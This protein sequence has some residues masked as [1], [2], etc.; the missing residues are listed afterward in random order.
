MWFALLLSLIFPAVAQDRGARGDDA[1]FDGEDGE[2]VP[3]PKRRFYYANSVFARV[4]PL[5]LINQFRLGIRRRL[6]TS[7]SVL[8]QDTYAFVGP[9]ATVSPAF[10]RGGLYAEAQLLSVFRVFAQVEGAQF[11]GTFNQVTSF[12]STDVLYS[13]QT[14]DTLDAAEALGGWVF[15]TGFTVRGAAGPLVVR[16]TANIA[17]F[18]IDL[19]EGRTHFY[20]Q[21]WDRLA[22]NNGWQWLQDTDLLYRKNKILAGVRYTFSDGLDG[23]EGD[24]GLSHHRV[25]PLLAYQFSSKKPGARFNQPTAFLLAQWWAQ[26]PY[27]T[28]EEQ[29]AG[30]PLIALGFAFNGDFSTS[31]RPAAN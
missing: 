4:N 2:Y 21:I 8:M 23:G 26:H 30:L 3:P 14:L 19:P 13:D 20:D 31:K 29:P 9:I 22:P 12:D 11:F 17:R 15:V 5:G 24:G 10:A 18:S 1:S 28:G 7:D 16:T 27:R 6:S 25:G